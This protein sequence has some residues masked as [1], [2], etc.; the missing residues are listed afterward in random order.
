MNLTG[1]TKARKYWLSFRGK[2]IQSR[3]GQILVYTGSCVNSNR[4]W[5]PELRCGVYGHT[6]SWNRPHQGQPLGCPKC[7]ALVHA[8]TRSGTRAFYMYLRRNGLDF[9]SYMQYHREHAD[10]NGFLRCEIC[11][12]IDRRR[13]CGDHKHDG[14]QSEKTYR[15]GLLC[16]WC[17]DLIGRLENN[18]PSNFVDMHPKYVAYLRRWSLVIAGRLRRAHD[19]VA[20]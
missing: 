3:M 5:H 8:E 12:T 11:G 16:R 15:R 6:F 14:K 7:R 2:T 20:V 17:N 10:E 19:N 13:L 1:E 4:A 9:E 18:A